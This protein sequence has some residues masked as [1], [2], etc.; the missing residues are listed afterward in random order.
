MI[1]EFTEEDVNSF[2]EGACGI[3]WEDA[4]SQLPR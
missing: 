3:P 4:L 1:S 2:R